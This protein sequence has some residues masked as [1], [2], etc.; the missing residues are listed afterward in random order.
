MKTLSSFL[1]LSSFALV[2]CSAP[3]TVATPVPA[4]VTRPATPAPAPAP[5]TTAPAVSTYV[6]AVALTEPPTN[7]HLLDQTA[8]K[9]PGSA[10]TAR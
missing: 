9:I 1:L 4:P 6:P 8:D 5:T 7:W 10:R 3:S 2:S